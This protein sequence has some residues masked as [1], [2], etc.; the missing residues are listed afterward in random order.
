M[1]N[2]QQKQDYK[3][4][5]YDLLFLNTEKYT[6]SADTLKN[7]GDW[8]RLVKSFSEYMP[9]KL[10]KQSYEAILSGDPKNR[11]FRAIYDDAFQNLATIS[12]KEQ[13]IRD[14]K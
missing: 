13:R 10:Y 1:E 2:E 8:R 5:L 9:Q 11:T 12:R 14:E 3:A 7:L 6:I 4:K